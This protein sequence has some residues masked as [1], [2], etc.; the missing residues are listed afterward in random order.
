MRWYKY[1]NNSEKD[2]TKGKSDFCKNIFLLKEALVAQ[3]D[4]II[5]TGLSGSGKSAALKC[6]EDLNF[7]CVDNLPPQLVAKFGQLSA[8][9][10]FE[11]VA[12]AVDDSREDFTQELREAIITIAELDYRIQII[13]L[14][15]PNEILI[16]RFS[17]NYH[18]HPLASAEGRILDAIRK[19]RTLLEEIRG[20]ADRI[21]DTG[22]L[23]L[24]QLKEEITKLF[25]RWENG[26][27]PITITVLSFGY[28]FGIPRD[29]DIVFDGRVLPNPFYDSLLRSLDGT[30]E[31]VQGY[32]FKEENGRE[33]MEKISEMTEFLL[34]QYVTKG[35]SHLTIAIGCTGGRHRSVSL[36]CRLAEFLQ[37]KNYRVFQEHRDLA[38]SEGGE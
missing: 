5:I 38:R 20:Q 8:S 3:K 37:K 15:A 30:N 35:K 18:K 36:T 2:H 19:E 31:K 17:A 26:S 23:T 16:R 10:G 24:R 6:L 25:F 21:I 9:S 11:Q 13:F 12:I 14:D 34:P 27:P 33:Y 32:V 7:F 4:F 1:I 28:K 22:D 29:A